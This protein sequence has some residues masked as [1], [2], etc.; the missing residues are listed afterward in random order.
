MKIEI[1]TR[2][3]LQDNAA[4]HYDRSKKMRAK[5]EGLKKAIVATKAAII[6]EERRA[7]EAEELAIPKKKIV[8]EKEWYEKFHWFFTSGGLLA[9]GGRDAKSN[10]VVVKKHMEP[11]DLFFHADVVGA[12]AVILKNGQSASE[13]DLKETAQF[14]ACYSRAWASSTE[15]VDVYAVKPDQV[16]TAAKAGEYLA[17]G[18]FVMIG[19]RQWF[20]KMSLRITLIFKD[21]KLQAALDGR[22]L[23]I[24]PHDR[25]TKGESAKKLLKKLREL[26]PEAEIDLDLVL[27][28]LP[29]GGSRIVA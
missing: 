28:L 4:L 24:A 13:Q 14:A 19:E 12:S 22:G 9:I 23:I 2:R 25:E 15:A 27:Q 1:D 26:F 11:K 17:K 20:R 18:A 6:E 16:K 21:G 29:N 5:L 3:S 8:R 10:E 7:S